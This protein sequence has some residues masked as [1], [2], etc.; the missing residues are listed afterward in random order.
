MKKP[1]NPNKR[2]SSAQIV[3]RGIFDKI[4]DIKYID[5]PIKWNFVL[6]K[7]TQTTHEYDWE[8]W[9]DKWYMYLPSWQK[10]EDWISPVSIVDVNINDWKLFISFSD[11]TIKDLWTVVWKDAH[12]ITVDDV[13]V[14]LNS[15][16]KFID[17]VKWKDGSIWKDWKSVNFDDVVNT[18]KNDGNLL[19][20]LKWEPWKDWVSPKIDYW[21]II[22]IIRQ[23]AWFIESIRWLPWKDW[24]SP[25]IDINKI[26]SILKQDESFINTT[27]WLPW[28]DWVS[29][30]V[31]NIIDGLK[32]DAEFI[33][34]IK[35]KD[36]KDCSITIKDVA[37]YIK[38]DTNFVDSIKW[39]DGIW[40]QGVPWK[41]WESI[42]IWFSPDWINNIT[43][44]Y[45]EWD[46]FMYVRVWLR[47]HNVFQIIK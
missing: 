33:D 32:K 43:E 15:D 10:W 9:I 46:R 2:I 12:Q 16:K 4:S 17:S 19:M 40:Y 3:C 7:E 45:K 28:K 31:Q 44:V 37:D 38:K 29:P 18:L 35:W 13:I 11:W 23:D 24:V 36:G 39:K 26:I 30:S 21:N 27:K 6:C 47:K 42:T 25:S 34:M 20:K 22:N 14:R 41:D 8:C 1:A 5:S